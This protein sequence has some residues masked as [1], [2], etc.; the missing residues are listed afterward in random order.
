MVIVGHTAIMTCPGVRGTE[1][2]TP[3]QVSLTNIVATH[4]Y[5]R[6][7]E[8]TCGPRYGHVHVRVRRRSQSRAVEGI[9]PL[10]PHTYG[11]P[12]FDLA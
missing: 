6:I 2:I 9:R 8:L 10:R 1:P 4:W 12:I 7:D 5:T 3:D 11:E